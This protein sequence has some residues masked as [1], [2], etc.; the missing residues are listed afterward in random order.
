MTDPTGSVSQ[1]APTP[2]SPFAIWGMIGMA[3]VFFLFAATPVILDAPWW[4]ITALLLLWL[5]LFMSA[6]RRFTTRPV[7]VA[8][9]PAVAGVGWFCFVIASARWLGW[10]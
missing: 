4:A 3:C 1:P 5:A 2:A 6:A 7:F 8:V 10:A 9:V